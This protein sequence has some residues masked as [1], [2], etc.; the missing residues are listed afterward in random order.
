[1]KVQS[2]LLSAAVAALFAST[3][4]AAILYNTP[5]NTYTQNFD[6]LPSTP[7]NTSLGNSPVGWTDD[8]A[9]PAAGNFS[10]VGF[11]LWHPVSQTEGGFNNHQRMHRRRHGEHRIVHELRLHSR[12]P[13]PGHVEFQHHGCR[14]P[15]RQL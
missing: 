3:A 6:A 9:L 5:G 8:N 12:R 13:G 7:L 11:H 2:Y 1:M 4:Q 14:P 15:G 10:I